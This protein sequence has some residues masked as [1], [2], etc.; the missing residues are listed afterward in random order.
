MEDNQLM[1]S[2]IVPV[3]NCE[4]YVS[5]L[6]ESVLKQKYGQYELILIN[7]GSTDGSLAIC[8]KYSEGNENIKVIDKKNTGVSDTRNIG[9]KEA[10]G[11]YI[12]FLDADDYIDDDYLEFAIDILKQYNFN[13][14]LVN[15]GIYTEVE[16]KDNVFMEEMKYVTKYYASKEE[17]KKDLINLWD[18]HMLD[19]PVNKVYVKSIIE[20]NNLEFDKLDFGED[21]DFNMRYVNCIS[22]LYNSEKCF[23]HY[24]RERKGAATEKY[25]KDLFQLRENEYL[26]FNKYFENNNLKFDEYIEFSSRRFI[27]RVVGC[28]ENVCSSKLKLKEKRQAIKTMINNENVRYALNYAKPKSKKMKILLFPIKIKSSGLFLLTSSLASYLK[29]ANPALFYKLKNKR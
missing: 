3:Y 20:K 21:L 19:N 5:K 27:E 18:A 7:D 9:I 1:F 2:I 11:K 15:T 10:V 23:Y 14:D 17:I 8:Q 16:Y 6:I 4:K 26:K 24:I 12:V 28:A 13:L 25:K 29:K 22:T